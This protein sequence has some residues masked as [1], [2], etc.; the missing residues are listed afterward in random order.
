V[1]HFGKITEVDA[2]NPS[3][4]ANPLKVQEKVFDG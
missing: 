4:N 1:I 2:G 3:R